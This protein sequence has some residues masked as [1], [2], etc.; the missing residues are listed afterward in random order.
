ML[1]KAV[2]LGILHQ[3][4]SCSICTVLNMFKLFSIFILLKEQI[5]GECFSA[6]RLVTIAPGF[7]EI[8]Q[9]QEGTLSQNCGDQ[10]VVL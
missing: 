4:I 6:G 9:F 10:C 2:L 1:L 7:Q 8:R 5:T 3:M